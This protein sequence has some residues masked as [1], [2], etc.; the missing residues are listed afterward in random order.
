MSLSDSP[1]TATVVVDGV[2]KNYKLRNRRVGN[3]LTR[4]LGGQASTVPALRDI[5]FATFERESIGVL[6]QNGSGKSTLMKI[7]AGGET[8]TAGHVLT[9]SQP[10][11]LSINAA[12][13]TKL[14]G[15]DN[16]RL[17][18]L[19]AGVHPNHVEMMRDQIAQ[20]ADLGAAIDRPMETYSSGM[21]ARLRFGIATAVNRDILLIDEALSVGD[22]AFQDRAKERMDELL[23]KS[24]TVFIVSHSAATVELNCTRAIWLHRGSIVAD[25][26]AYDVAVA[27]RDWAIAIKENN[28]KKAK[29]LVNKAISTHRPTEIQYTT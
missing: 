26:S 21:D 18:L 3:P 2:S 7:I 9:R 1:R 16:I 20:F 5:T 4:L 6:G 10:T 24:G 29:A 11:L 17:G 23:A 28:R 19:A 14:T 27:Y 13:Q 25:G 12:L 15:E 8:P 22:A